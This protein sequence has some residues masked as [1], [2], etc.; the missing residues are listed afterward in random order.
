MPENTLQ[1]NVIA[2]LPASSGVLDWKISDAGMG[3][4]DWIWSGSGSL[5]ISGDDITMQGIP[6]SRVSGILLSV[7]LPID[8]PLLSIHFSDSSSLGSD[9]SLRLS[10]EVLQNLQDISY[11]GITY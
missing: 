6:G 4:E 2:D 8:A 10:V 9:Y 5:S 1:W 11:F 3:I 7:E